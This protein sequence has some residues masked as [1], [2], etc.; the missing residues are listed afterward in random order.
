MA[1]TIG[2]FDKIKTELFKEYFCAT[3][4]GVLLNQAAAPDMNTSTMASLNASIVVLSGNATLTG[5][6]IVGTSAAYADVTLTAAGIMKIDLSDMAFT[7]STGTN[8]TAKFG[9]LYKSRS[10]TAPVFFWEI[11][12]ASVVASQINVTWPSGG[13]FTTDDNV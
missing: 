11:S 6:Q 9:A 7:A 12:T 13:V 3:F 2:L 4:R 8:M 1:N 10:A 5:R